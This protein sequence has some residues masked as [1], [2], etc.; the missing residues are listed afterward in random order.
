[1]EEKRKNSNEG[2]QV[3]PCV[4]DAIKLSRKDRE[5]TLMM[6]QSVRKVGNQWM[7]PYSWR[8]NSAGLPDKE[9]AITR[10][11]ST[12]RQL[13]KKPNEAASYDRKIIEME[14]MNLASKLTEKEVEEYKGPFHYIS[15][16]AALRPDGASV[17]ILI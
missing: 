7:I 11:E 14:K 3:D 12:E 8:R 17:P 9:Q 16:H 13:L 5:E 10:L 15:H 2:V 6:Q 4:C 1:M